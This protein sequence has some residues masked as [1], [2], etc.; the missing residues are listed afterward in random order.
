MSESSSQQEQSGII[1]EER[2]AIEEA[3]ESPQADVTVG[4]GPDSHRLPRTVKGAQ[5]EPNWEARYNG[6]N[7]RYQ[8]DREE[9]TRQFE[10]LRKQLQ[11]LTSTSSKETAPAASESQAAKAQTKPEATGTTG[12]DALDRAIKQRKAETYRN[13]MVEQVSR[14]LGI[15]ELEMFSDNIEIVPPTF[16]GDELDNSGQLAAIRSFADKLR[17]VQGEASRRTQDVIRKG[18]TPGAAP[19]VTAPTTGDD[20]YQEFLE[21]MEVY[22]SDE[23]SQ[24]P[25]A[26]QGR[27]ER[28]YFELLDDEAVADRHGGQT[29]PTMSWQEMQQTVRDLAKA[30]SSGQGRGQTPFGKMA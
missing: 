23:F 21:V 22:G 30:V 19:G 1:T 24:L 2:S 20:V 12:V 8:A 7:S 28:R 25:K 15:P 29:R 13:L 3:L 16:D 27:I 14:E 6:L 4:R 5:E 11:Q 9:W 18:S 10:D 17:G 26:D